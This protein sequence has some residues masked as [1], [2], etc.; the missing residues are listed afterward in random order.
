MAD[1]VLQTLQQ[2]Y[3]C[4][5]I[6]E[7]DAPYLCDYFADCHAHLCEY[8]ADCHAVKYSSA[9]RP[10]FDMRCI[11]ASTSPIGKR[12]VALASAHRRH[13]SG[14]PTHRHIGDGP[15]EIPVLALPEALQELYL[16]EYT[17]DWQA[18]A[19]QPYVMLPSNGAMGGVSPCCYRRHRPNAYLREPNGCTEHNYASPTVLHIVCVV[20]SESREWQLSDELL[21]QQLTAATRLLTECARHYSVDNAYGNAHSHVSDSALVGALQLCECETNPASAA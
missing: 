7:S 10:P 16:C 20:S 5:S 18:H 14:E 12:R 11:S 9:S 19:S 17:A 4:E 6:A 15:D 8:I 1:T 21:R 13:G 3:L 2:L